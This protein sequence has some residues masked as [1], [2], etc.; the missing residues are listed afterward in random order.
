MTSKKLLKKFASQT[1]A[2]VPGV[3]SE[4]NAPAASD[5]A[6]QIRVT[7]DMPSPEPQE[8]ELFKDSFSDLTQVK[9]WENPKF[10]GV[11]VLLLVLPFTLGIAWVFKDGIPKPSLSAKKPE[12]PAPE[13]S[14]DDQPKDATD[15]EWASF[16]ST[17]GM[18][19]N[20]KEA[21]ARD[22]A[23]ESGDTQDR[24]KGPQS[25]SSPAPATTTTASAPPVDNPPVYRPTAVR[26]YSPPPPAPVSV[27]PR[28]TQYSAYKPQAVTPA[29]A[30]AFTPKRTSSPKSK[31][32][33]TPSEAQQPTPQERIAAIIAA[34]STTD[35]KPA[36]SAS[37]QP[38]PEAT[39]TIAQPPISSIYSGR[40]N[41]AIVAS[42]QPRPEVIPASTQ[43]PGVSQPAETYQQ[44]PYLPSEAAVIQ[45]QAQTVIERSQSAQG[46]LQ[47]SIA[48][49]SGDYGSLAGEPVEI[50][51]T[52]ELGDIPAG[53][54]IIAV[55]DAG[56][57]SRSDRSDPTKAEVVRLVPSAIVLGE[58][59]FPLP[60]RSILLSGE[61]RT[62]L[63]AKRGGSKVLRFLG[64]LVGTV[65][66]GAGLT[67]FGAAQ[68]VQIGD[69]SYFQSV[70][71]N[72]AT[73]V[74]SNAAQQLQQAGQTGSEVLALNAGSPITVSVLKPFAMP[75]LE[76]V[77]NP[78]A[79]VQQPGP[80]RTIPVGAYRNPSDEE[81]MTMYIQAQDAIEEDGNAAQ[82]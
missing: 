77:V 61:D 62:P 11:V 3:E 56:Q 50:E 36:T 49:T 25:S 12:A 53:S 45:G 48:F 59:E 54:R 34:T 14:I 9:P 65:T 6:D 44:A 66:G 22:K 10:K 24:A 80:T 69:S 70:G 29:R 19:Q 47:T 43:M 31:P 23:Q 71:T 67:N 15:G 38:R 40:T 52:E 64:G 17:N 4:P 41:P 68:N 16:A 81:L 27:T 26:S 30:T 13:P 20:F 18:H 76:N 39:S 60:D 42:A 75:R 7:T 33:P 57:G 21:E 5:K 58:M 1:G 79:I 51:L 74:I 37:A 2:E 55:I 35:G 72:V 8:E 73:A 82:N 32:S 78:P 63:I 28:R 46:V